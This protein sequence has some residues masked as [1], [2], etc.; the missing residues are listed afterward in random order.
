[1]T[2]GRLEK[3][4]TPGRGELGQRESCAQIKTEEQELGKKVR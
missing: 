3:K 1:M 4:W 2:G